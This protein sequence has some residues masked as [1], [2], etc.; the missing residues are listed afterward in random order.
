MDT[1]QRVICGDC[2]EV[3]KKLPENSIDIL[4]TDPP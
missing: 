2:V 3:L 1:K 4:V